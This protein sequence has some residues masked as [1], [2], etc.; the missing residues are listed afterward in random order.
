MSEI[1]YY[2]TNYLLNGIVFIIGLS[3]AFSVFV[4]SS[5]GAIKII[6]FLTGF[7]FSIL[8]LFFAIALDLAS[9]NLT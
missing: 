7:A 6:L 3:V 4:A 9:A 5:G 8:N 1:L 2:Q